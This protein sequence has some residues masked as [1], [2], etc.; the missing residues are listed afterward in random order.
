L[1]P[2]V[3]R[4]ARLDEAQTV[5]DLWR[6][7]GASVSST[8][9]LPDVEA[10]IRGWPGALLVATDGEAVVGTIIATFDGWRA[11][12][13]RLVVDV[14][15]RRRGLG[16]ALVAEAERRLRQLGAKRVTALVEADQPLAVSFWEAGPY[17]LHANM[18]RYYR[19]L[20]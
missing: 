4:D 15:Y 8:D 2:F 14:S 10:L 19:G 20:D 6:R 13:Y 5:L 12:L 18:V 3:I 1:L 17:T 7:A 9:T 11:N 16:R